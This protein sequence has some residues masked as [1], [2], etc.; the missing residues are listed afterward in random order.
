MTQ[1]KQNIEHIKEYIAAKGFSY[2]NALIENLY[3]SLKAKPFVIL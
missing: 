3:L 1:E 2:K